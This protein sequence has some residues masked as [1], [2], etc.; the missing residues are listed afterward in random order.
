MGPYIAIDDC[1][2]YQETSYVFKCMQCDLQLQTDIAAVSRYEPHMIDEAV[3]R[4]RFD[5]GSMLQPKDN[6]LVKSS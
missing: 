1:V 3:I 5:P 4:I 6:I 2:T